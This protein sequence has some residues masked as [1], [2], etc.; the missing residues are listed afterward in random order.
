VR[1]DARRVGVF[2]L[3]ESDMP[4]RDKKMMWIVVSGFVASWA[5]LVYVAY[6]LGLFFD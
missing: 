5:T 4:D 6:A 1:V 3:R 2:Q